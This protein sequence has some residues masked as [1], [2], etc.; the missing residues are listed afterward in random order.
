MFRSTLPLICTLA[1]FS[2]FLTQSDT[3]QS[4]PA[5]QGVDWRFGVIESYESPADAA[6]LGAAWTRVRFQWA[7]VQAGGPGTW[8]PTVSDSQING[9]IDGGRAVIGLLIGVPSWASDGNGLPNGLWLPHDSPENSWTTMCAKPSP[10]TMAE[11]AIGSSGTNQTY[12]TRL[13]LVTPG[14]ALCAISSN[15]CASPTSPPNRSTPMSRFTWG[16]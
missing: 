15:C 1:L 4:A 9:E 8:T 11:L 5:T 6:T 7:D 13:R 2:L 10:G 14:T 3:A 16:R 12:A